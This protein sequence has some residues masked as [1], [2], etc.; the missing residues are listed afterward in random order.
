MVS[1]IRLPLSDNSLILKADQCLEYGVRV[2]VEFHHYIPVKQG[3]VFFEQPA[4]L[5]LGANCACFKYLEVKFHTQ[6]Y[7]ASGISTEFM[8]FSTD[9][10]EKNLLMK[11]SLSFSIT[12]R[13]YPF[14]PISDRTFSVRCSLLMDW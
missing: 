5:S 13:S 12:S 1:A 14:S 4:D 11:F 6:E 2:S 3:T 7:M 10:L 8:I 9:D